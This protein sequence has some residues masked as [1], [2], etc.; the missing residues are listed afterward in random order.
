MIAP[1]CVC[2]IYL[3]PL[4]SC[5]RF[6]HL[7][8]VLLPG[9]CHPTHRFHWVLVTQW[10]M[11][12]PNRDWCRGW[13]CDPALANETAG[14]VSQGGASSHLGSRCGTEALP[15]ALSASGCWCWWCDVW[16]CCNHLATASPRGFL[17]WGYSIL[18]AF[19]TFLI[20]D[21]VYMWLKASQQVPRPLQ[22]LLHGF[23]FPHLFFTSPSTFVAGGFVSS[24][25]S[26]FAHS[27]CKNTRVCPYV[28]EWHRQEGRGW[29]PSPLSWWPSQLQAT[30]M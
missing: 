29:R 11:W 5:H 15:K 1:S 7:K 25:T 10:M 26:P 8:F 13:A 20:R 17:S 19:K 23:S 16:S 22:F 3:F 4:Q 12:I 21:L 18:F 24:L 27:L 6:D 30:G 14:V 2:I 9:C 28:C